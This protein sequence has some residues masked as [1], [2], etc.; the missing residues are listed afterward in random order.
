MHES[1]VAKTSEPPQG[2]EETMRRMDE[3]LKRL[4]S[5]PHKPQSAYKVGKRKRH[6]SSEGGAP[7]KRKAKRSKPAR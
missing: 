5:T 1:K 3:V 4:L 2:E 7:V 6:E